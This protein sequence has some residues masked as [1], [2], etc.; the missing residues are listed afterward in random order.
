MASAASPPETWDCS[1]VHSR[2]GILAINDA[3]RD[4]LSNDLGAMVG[5]MFDIGSGRSTAR[6]CPGTTWAPR[7]PLGG[8]S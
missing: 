3:V 7:V 4:Q 1:E 2:E 6:R 5:L 8:L